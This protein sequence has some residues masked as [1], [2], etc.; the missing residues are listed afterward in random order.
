[1]HLRTK[2]LLLIALL[3]IALLVNLSA[4]LLLAQTFS[5]SLQTIQDVAIQQQTTALQMQALL[6]DAEAALYRYQIE[7]EAGFAIQFANRLNEFGQ[8]IELFE[9]LASGGQEQAWVA[10]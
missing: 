2:L 4:L 5:H 6:R 10:E 1:M 8:E 3:S 7:G 9:S